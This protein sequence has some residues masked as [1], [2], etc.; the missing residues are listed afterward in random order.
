M[1]LLQTW[2]NDDNRWIVGALL[3]GLIVLI[4]TG[5]LHSRNLLRRPRVR[6]ILR[7]TFRVDGNTWRLVG[8][9]LLLAAACA[10]MCAEWLWSPQRH[11]ATDSPRVSVPPW[12]KSDGP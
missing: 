5:L 2:F 12:P 6:N 3:F 8:L 10:L 9:L 11:G 4:L 1:D 7:T